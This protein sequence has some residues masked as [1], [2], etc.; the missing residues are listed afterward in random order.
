MSFRGRLRVFFTIIVIV[1]MIAVGAV[2]Y[3]L[4]ADSETGKA[5]A[6]IA[7]GLRTAI[8]LYDISS[9]RAEPGLRALAANMSVVDGLVAGGPRARAALRKAASLPGV[10]RVA[11]RTEDSRQTL[12][13]GRD[14][15][16][17][18]AGAPL[19][20]RRG[21]RLGTLAVSVT[22]ARA[23]ATQLRKLTGLQVGLSRGRLLADTRDGARMVPAGGGDFDLRGEDY[24]GRAD[25]F[26]EVLG[27]PV[28][29]AVYD[30]VEELT[31]SVGSS[32]LLI[33]GI[34]L[35]FLLLALASSVF[36]VRALQ[37]QIG[38]FLD[39]A[40]RLAKGDFKHPVPTHGGDEFA[41]L[42]RE[43][44][45]MSEQ[46]EAKIEEL[47]RNRRELEETIRRV[48]AAFASGLDPQGIF[49]LTLDTAIDACDADGG[50]A[51]PLAYG[52]IDAFRRGSEAAT[53]TA[54]LA[55]AEGVALR[56]DGGPLPASG[57]A[58]E[59]RN[60]GAHALA[61][62]IRSPHGDH[63]HVGLVSIARGREFTREERELFEYLAGQAALSIEN[64]EL[65]ETVQRQA[66]TDELTGLS[67]LRELQSALDREIERSRR[68][69]SSLGLVMVDI[70][71]FKQ[72]NDVFG[73][74]QGDKVLVQVARVLRELSRDID[75]PAR[76]GGEELAVITPET[77]TAGAAHQ[78]ERMREAIEG[79]RVARLDGQGDLQITASFGVASLPDTAWDKDSLIAAADGALYRAKHAGKNRV[80]RAGSL[81]APRSGP[82]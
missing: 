37:D 50:R 78:A 65:H 53:T 80:E 25:R 14:S 60:R 71:N 18:A 82:R 75:E 33:G 17:A 22:S 6:G 13:A 41:L 48:G 67:N 81:T 49:E 47:D 26:R 7:A 39:A 32:R 15:G 34:I 20:D 30:P 38:R 2:L 62:S 23:Y 21:R 31:G 63:E 77:D 16:V 55:A 54:A 3:R 27:P 29:I 74:Q 66:V 28:T 73:H 76:Y 40:R 57:R 72:V 61:V 45:S 9:E 44:N 43:F 19:V 51:L 56:G 36:V 59:A 11:F 68:F 42:G 24:R 69:D 12:T 5:D 4:T 70:D 8:A 64:A 46:L 10:V 35:A 58:A 52:R 1:P 79:L